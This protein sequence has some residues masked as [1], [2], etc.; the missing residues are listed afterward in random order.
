MV[1]PQIGDVVA[2]QILKGI[3]GIRRIE[4]YGQFPSVIETVAV[5]ITAESRNCDLE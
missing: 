2:I 1:F 3:G 4:P 5:V